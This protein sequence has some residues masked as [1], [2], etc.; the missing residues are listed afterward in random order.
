MVLTD[1]NFASI[2]AAVEEGRNVFDNLVKF[3][4]WTLPTNGGEGLLLLAAIVLGAELPVLPVHLLWIN[5]STA[6][7]LGL[8][9]VFEPKEPGLMGRPPRD[10]SQPLLTRPLVMRTALVSLLM[11]VTGYGLF[12]WE[13]RAHG[14]SLEEAR[15]IVVNLIVVAEAFYLLNCRS[16][17]RSFVRSGWFSNRWVWIGI[18]VMLGAQALFNYLPL[19]NR[20]FHTAPVRAETWLHVTLAGFAIFLVVEL[21]KWVR[22][23]GSRGEHV[24]PE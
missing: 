21:E 22:Y 6:V 17:T 1:D 8:M 14:A 3:I 19:M 16:L 11:L 9:L 23:G 24:V 12:L 20:L 5:M 18:G 15:T 4:V 13:Q 2:K 7:L 10:P